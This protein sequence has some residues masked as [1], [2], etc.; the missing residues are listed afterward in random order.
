MKLTCTCGHCQVCK[1]RN[2]VRRYRKIEN[3][4]IAYENGFASGIVPSIMRPLNIWILI[5][6]N[7]EKFWGKPLEGPR[8]QLNKE[9]NF[10]GLSSI[11]I[12][13]LNKFQAKRTYMD[14]KNY[15]KR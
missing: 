1:H 13:L 6:E 10:Y 12:G 15:D 9:S 3:R 14:Y 4:E 8:L 7:L 5:E 11:R 2:N